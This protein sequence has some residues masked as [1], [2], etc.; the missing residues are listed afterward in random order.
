MLSPLKPLPG[1]PQQHFIEVHELLCNPIS[2]Y[3]AG[4]QAAEAHGTTTAVTA[5]TAVT[6][7]VIPYQNKYQIVTVP[8]LTYGP[9]QTGLAPGRCQLSAC[10]S[11]PAPLPLSTPS[12]AKSQ[13]CVHCTHVHTGC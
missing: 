2:L 8:R 13:E 7:A 5:V 3:A 11:A 6:A 12:H 4:Q 9:C 10:I 1:T